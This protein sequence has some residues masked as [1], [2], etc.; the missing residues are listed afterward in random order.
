MTSKI[1]ENSQI[2]DAVRQVARM[3]K[4]A[5]IILIIY[6]AVPLFI[7]VPIQLMHLHIIDLGPF[8]I[9]FM[10]S[11]AFIITGGVFC[12]K[13]KYWK[14]CFVSAL[15]A[16]FMMIYW[17]YVLTGFSLSDFTHPA[18]LAWYVLLLIIII[19]GALPIIFVC[20]R[21]RKWQKI[22]A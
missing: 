20:I 15:L 9:F 2:R 5:C 8:E 1:V 22:P 6:G 14:L 19:A 21:K 17:I 13:R 18:F 10:I 12:L 4:A 7:F 11:P 16:V 3:R